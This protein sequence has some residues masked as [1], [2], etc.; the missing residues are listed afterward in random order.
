MNNESPQP[1]TTDAGTLVRDVMDKAARARLVSNVAA[2][3][4]DG[5]SKVLQRAFQCWKDVHNEIGELIVLESTPQQV[6]S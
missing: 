3:L 5:V 1:S 6:I 2:R 4:R